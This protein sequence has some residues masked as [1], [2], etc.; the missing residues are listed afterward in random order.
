MAGSKVKT[1]LVMDM[2]GNLE[3]KAARYT[4]AIKG[5][6]DRGEVHMGRMT[7][8]SRFMGRGLDRLGG[9]YAG[10][11]AVAGLGYAVTQV[12]N[13]QERYT[14]LGIQ[15]DVSDEKIA[16]LRQQVLDVAIASD[17]QLNP[18]KITSA[19]ESILEKTGDLEFA[20]QNI[21]NIGL[22]IRATGAEGGAIGDLFSE[23]QKQGIKAPE[24]VLRAIDTLNVQG[25]EGAFTLK[26]LA[27]LGPRVVAAYNAL[28][29]SGVPAMRE[30]GAALQVIRQGTGSSEQAATAFE[31]MLRTFSDNDKLK[32]LKDLGGIQVFDLDALAKG[33][34]KLRPINELMVEIVEAA[35]GKQL[36]LS[37]VFD[38]EALRAFNSILG[39]FNRDGG[40]ES[41]R[42]FMQVQGDGAAT[43]NDAA[44]A[45]KNYNAALERLSTSWD[46]FA[47]S[48][49]T[50]PVQ[51]LA[52][53][54][55]GINE[56]QVQATL[57]TAKWA[58]GLLGV[59]IAGRKV[60]KY[61]KAIAA[62]TGFSPGKGLAT[63][64]ALLGGVKLGSIGMMGAGALGTA[65]AG[66]GAAGA[67][68]YGVGTLGYKYFL[69]GTE[70]SDS[71][72]GAI[73]KAMA[74]LG[75]D[76]AQAAVNSREKSEALVRLEVVGNQAVKVRHI[77]ASGLDVD[78]DAG[79]TMGIN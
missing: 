11:A 28:G 72:G 19:I 55:N 30:M 14:M 54:I 79:A 50:E 32:K 59:S 33:E 67:A 47:E 65:A 15:A 57:N 7:R 27:M 18:D 4:K 26:N 21:R 25:K 44:R 37:Q 13:L 6:A 29:R 46:K 41:L 2:E 66:V 42:K 9:R 35:K 56:G 34:N 24:Q 17:V 39:E 61:Y 45:A 40:I 70:F 52:D 77:S 78:V 36:N 23:F 76:N 62:F 48:N 64:A 3:R 53:S 5:M 68:G 16:G 58:A 20:E 38:A 75:N 12:G 63:K 22:A 69:E 51:D 43:T 60:W 10:L 49:L 1:S 71:L 31:A 73:A 74:F 8:A